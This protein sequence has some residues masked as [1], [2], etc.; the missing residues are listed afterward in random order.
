MA[1]VCNCHRIDTQ[2][3]RDY[4]AANG[5]VL[6]ERDAKIA[7]KKL[8]DAAKTARVAEGLPEFPNGGLCA[9]CVNAMLEHIVKESRAM[10]PQAYKEAA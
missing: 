5:P 1:V 7:R 10:Y 3:I 9:R 8:H 6:T 4:L 2:Q